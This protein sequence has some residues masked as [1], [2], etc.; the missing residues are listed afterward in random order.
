VTADD[1]DSRDSFDDPRSRIYAARPVVDECSAAVAEEA[2]VELTL[3]RTPMYL[4]DGLAGLHAVESL[5][6]QLR[7]WL[8][9]VVTVARQQGHSWD[10]IAGQLEVTP[11]T[12]RRRYN[13]ANTATGHEHEEVG[14]CAGIFG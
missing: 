2:V 13:R 8:P 3:L 10:D 5:M 12:A 1:R 6:A 9:G 7:A 14:G 4:G 11:A